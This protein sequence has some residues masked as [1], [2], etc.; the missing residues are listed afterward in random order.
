MENNKKFRYEFRLAPLYKIQLTE[1]PRINT[2]KIILDIWDLNKGKISH[3]VPLPFDKLEEIKSI[4]I[5]FRRVNQILND[6]EEN[7]GKRDKHRK[8]K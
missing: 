8:K 7:R 1:T 6:Y 5:F 4:D 3:S 2:N